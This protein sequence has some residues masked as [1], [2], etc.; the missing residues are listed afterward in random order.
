M[1]G[2]SIHPPRAGRD[3]IIDQA[4]KLLSISI[5]PPRAGRDLMMLSML[6]V[7]P[8]FQ[9]TRPVRGGTTTIASLSGSKKISIH[10]PR[11]GRD[12]KAVT[13]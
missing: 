1:E 3:A 10:P 6:V 4:L 11:A 7:L 5:H 2:I 9:S 13:G 8:I 12:T